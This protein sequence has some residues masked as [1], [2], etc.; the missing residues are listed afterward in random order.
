MSS[1]YQGGV[2]DN[3]P[4]G[5][6]CRVE[7]VEKTRSGVIVTTTNASLEE[8]LPDGD[9]HIDIPLVMPGQQSTFNRAADAP[10]RVKFF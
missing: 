4:Y 10:S 1:L 5:F 6:L 7:A 8:V 9:Y 2:T 3:A